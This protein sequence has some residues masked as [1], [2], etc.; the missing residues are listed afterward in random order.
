MAMTIIIEAAIKP[1][2]TSPPMN[3]APTEALAI[4]A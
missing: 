1:A 3:I 2:G 4:S